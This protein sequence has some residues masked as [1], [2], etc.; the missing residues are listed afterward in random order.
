MELKKRYSVKTNSV[1]KIEQLLQETYDLACQQQN[2]IQ[3]EINKITNTTNLVELDIDGKE[4]YGK[5]L[6]NYIKLQQNA[7]AQKF[8]IAKLLSEILK[9]DGDVNG[10]LNDMKNVSTKIDINKLR[11]IAKSA[12]TP[13]EGVES[14]NIK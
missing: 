11:E 3:N 2:Q 13:A 7:I 14:Y 1:E 12:S 9:H 4:K 8:D 10:A 5:T 6:A